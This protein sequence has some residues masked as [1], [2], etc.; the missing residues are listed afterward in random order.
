[1][2]GVLS[3]GAGAAVTVEIRVLGGEPGDTI[4]LVS[5]NGKRPRLERPQ[6]GSP[7]EKRSLTFTSDGSYDWVRAN[8]RGNDGRLLL[9]TNPVYL[10]LP[11]E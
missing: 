2:G 1:M 8:L 7:D 3:V 5:R 6:I 4:E 11:G 9:L 10:N